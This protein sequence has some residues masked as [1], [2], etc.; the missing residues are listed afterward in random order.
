MERVYNVSAVLET[1]PC[2]KTSKEQAPRLRYLGAVPTHRRR[3][4]S[5]T[6]TPPE[7]S[8]AIRHGQIYLWLPSYSGGLTGSFG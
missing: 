8:G 1:K 6:Y 3:D 2:Y 5:A 7:Y 4:W